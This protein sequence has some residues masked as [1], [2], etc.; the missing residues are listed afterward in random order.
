M[1]VVAG[2]TAPV[3]LND[4][5]RTSPQ[6]FARFLKH[7]DAGWYFD[8]CSHHPYTPSG[9]VFAAPDKPPNDPTTSVTLYN[10]GALPRLFPARP[11]YLTEDGYSTRFSREAAQTATR[12]Q[13]AAY[14]RRAYKFVRKYPRVRMLLW[15]LLYDHRPAGQPVE[16]GIYSGLREPDGTRKP[17][18][19]ASRDVRPW[20]APP[21]A[22][23]LRLV[24][25]KQ[26]EHV[27]KRPG[28]RVI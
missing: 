18:W 16:M 10:L 20:L 23:G 2:A 14:L 19:Y 13:Q 7:Q 21:E 4:R 17:A 5:M 1:R 22:A 25:R 27:E 26:A 12:A 6:R 3:G 24:S 8:G 11:F 9:T 15:F 28:R